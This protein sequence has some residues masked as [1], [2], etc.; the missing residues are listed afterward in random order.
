MCYAK[1][2]HGL[3]GSIMD[4]T[5]LLVRPQMPSYAAY[6]GGCD[7]EGQV[8]SSESD[9]GVHPRGTERLGSRRRARPGARLMK[10][11]ESR[12]RRNKLNRSAAYINI[13]G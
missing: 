1:D 10:A 13:H 8:A 5:K 6:Q 3:H 7:S 9:L 11:V 4:G 12:Q 2:T